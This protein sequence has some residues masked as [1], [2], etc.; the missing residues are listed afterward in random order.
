MCAT[1]SFNW[2]YYLETDNG[3]I[4]YEGYSSKQWKKH[5]DHWKNE[6]RLKLDSTQAVLKMNPA[7]NSNNYP[8]G[9]FYGNMFDPG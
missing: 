4:Y 1:S 6:D 2:N 3:E 5:G 9:M 7:E 8:I